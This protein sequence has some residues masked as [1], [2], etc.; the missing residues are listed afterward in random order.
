ME[1]LAIAGWP[2]GLGD[3]PGREL[4]K[5]PPLSPA[6]LIEANLTEAKGW[7]PARMRVYRTLPPG[8]WHPA[9]PGG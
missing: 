2:A 9:Y 8:M 1:I 4:A 5:L 3:A 7:P 6:S